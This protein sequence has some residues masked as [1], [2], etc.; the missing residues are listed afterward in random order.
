[1]RRLGPRLMGPILPR[2]CGAESGRPDRLV[3]IDL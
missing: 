1:M 3:K 2:W